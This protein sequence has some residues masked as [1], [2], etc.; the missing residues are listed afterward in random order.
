MKIKTIVKL[1]TLTIVAGFVFTGMG[2]AFD[3][4]VFIQ[5]NN[6]STESDSTGEEYLVDSKELQVFK[7]INIEADLNNIEI[8]PSNQYKLDLKYKKDYINIKYKIENETLSI[9]EEK[10]KSDTY[11]L[12]YYK[13]NKDSSIRIYIPKGT[14]LNNLSI[15][16]NISNVSLNELSVDNMDLSCDTGNINID[17]CKVEKLNTI[18]ATGGINVDGLD[19]LDAKFK[20]NMGNINILNGSIRENLEL[21]NN[22]GYTKFKGEILG[23]INVSNNLGN[24]ELDIDKNEDEYNYNLKSDSGNIIINDEVKSRKFIKYNKSKF[25]MNLKCN[26]GDINLKFN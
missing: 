11:N 9:K 18:T 3:E 26:S 8:I 15:S 20:S 1:S 24:I 22:L 14:K 7:N 2:Y 25:D 12:E 16:S 19:S 10:I 13:K 23:N 4:N 6:F 17:K 5:N 21:S